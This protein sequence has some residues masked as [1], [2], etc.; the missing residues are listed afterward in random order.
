MANSSDD[1]AELSDES[2][3]DDK[4][5]AINQAEIAKLD[6]KVSKLLFDPAAK[7]LLFH[8]SHKRM[9]EVR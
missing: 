8:I 3:E 5:E 4:E 7:V 1:D 2:M 9:F 6:E